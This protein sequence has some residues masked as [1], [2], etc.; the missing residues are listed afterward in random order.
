MEKLHVR[1][2]FFCRPIGFE[3]EVSLASRTVVDGDAGLA[4][5]VRAF[6]TVG[7]V[8]IK[9]ILRVEAVMTTDGGQ[10]PECRKQI[11]FQSDVP[12]D[13]Y[14]NELSAYSGP[15]SRYMTCLLG[16]YELSQRGEGLTNGCCRDVSLFR[17]YLA[18]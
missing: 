3:V 16:K 8:P 17:S 11:F 18:F 7:G 13:V 12:S 6:S 15:A 4:G 5:T 2:D 1:L 9:G 10:K 14:S